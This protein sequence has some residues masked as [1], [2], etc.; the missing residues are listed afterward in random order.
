MGVAMHDKPAVAFRIRAGLIK[1]MGF[2]GQ[3]PHQRPMGLLDHPIRPFSRIAIMPESIRP[4][5]AICPLSQSHPHPDRQRLTDRFAAAARRL[6][7]LGLG[8]GMLMLPVQ[9]APQPPLN[10]AAAPRSCSALLPGDQ[11]FLEPLRLRPQD[12]PAKNA[13]GCLSPADAIYG[14]DGCPT[15][16]CP[17][18]KGFGFER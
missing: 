17:Q 13:M 7:L 18:P 8:G 10:G 12:V 3:A 14:L 5:G 15:R 16:L 1:M 9:A 2:K 4:R 6:A 11:S